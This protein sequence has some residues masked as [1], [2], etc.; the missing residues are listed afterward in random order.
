MNVLTPFV[1]PYLFAEDFSTIPSFSDGHDNPATGS[2]SD[3]YDE[4]K[5]LDGYASALVGWSG[6]RVGG[7]ANQ[8]LRMCC[9]F[10][11]G[12]FTAKSYKGRVDTAPLSAIK[13]GVNAKI[14]VTFDYGA[15]KEEYGTGSG[16]TTMTFGYT[17]NTGAIAPSSGISSV[18]VSGSEIADTT[19]SYSNL[20]SSY[21]A[22]IDG[23]NNATRLSW[24]SATTRGSSIGGNGNYWIYIDNIKVQIAK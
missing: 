11:S 2:N 24:Q 23:I 3:T 15:A 22:T 16:N 4:S 20:P 6:G 14:L 9:R 19:G 10:E 18:V 1:V 12:L 21:S 7:A 17:T 8:A 13:S 5:M